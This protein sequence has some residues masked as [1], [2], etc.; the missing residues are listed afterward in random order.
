MTAALNKYD[1]QKRRWTFALTFLMA[2]VVLFAGLLLS[3]LTSRVALDGIAERISACRELASAVR[4][5]GIAVLAFMWPNLVRR[6]VP[7][8]D[9]RFDQLQ[10]PRWRV[11]GWLLILEIVLGQN[12]LGRLFG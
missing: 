3:H 5:V 9:T 12:I 7:T 11:T 4:L 6:L 1:F 2:A 8:N 10:A